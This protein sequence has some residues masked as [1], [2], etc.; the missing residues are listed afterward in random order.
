M[1][2]TFATENRSDFAIAIFGVLRWVL[3]FER[4]GLMWVSHHVSTLQVARFLSG[5]ILSAC[6]T[7][8]FYGWAGIIRFNPDPLQQASLSLSLS[9]S[10]S[11]SLSLYLF[12]VCLRERETKKVRCMQSVALN[13]D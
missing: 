6:V 8:Q 10:I 2:G 3:P 4:D 13:C 12:L 1:T 7:C 11:R 5:C 9:L